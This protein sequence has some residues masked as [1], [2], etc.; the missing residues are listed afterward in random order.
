MTPQRRNGRAQRHHA[1]YGSARLGRAGAAQGRWAIV[2]RFAHDASPPE[3]LA[4][5]VA[6]QLLS[7][8]GVVFRDLIAR[9]D[10]AV[11][12]RD[13][14][15]ALRRQEARGVLRGGRFVAGFIGEQYALPEAVDAL[16]RVRK[17]ERNGEAVHLSAADPLNLAGIITPGPRIAAVHTKSVALRDGLPV[18]T[19]EASPA[20]TL[21]REPVA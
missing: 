5:S 4:E 15:R 11:P 10:T 18:A 8:Y 14:V 1:R 7:R 2:Q 3:E 20:R 19:G 9:E 6:M 17:A 13:I 12:W 21:D 16:R